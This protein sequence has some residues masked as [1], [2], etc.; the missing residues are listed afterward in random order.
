[1]RYVTPLT[2]TTAWQCPTCHRALPF[3]D[4]TWWVV[5]GGGWLPDLSGP[6]HP[7]RYCR[8]VPL[9]RVDPLELA[10]WSGL[11]SWLEAVRLWQPSVG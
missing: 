3:T 11:L 1:M 5:C 2:H 4:D 10:R 6:L 8:R 9:E 7:W